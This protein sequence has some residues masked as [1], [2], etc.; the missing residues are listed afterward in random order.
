MMKLRKK[1]VVYYGIIIILIIYIAFIDS[2][3]YFQRYRT[4]LKLE[5]VK[6]DLEA[7]IKENRRLQEENEKLEQ[8]RN[9]WEKKA[10]ELGMQKNGDEVFIFKEKK[11]IK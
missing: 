3:S 4:Q 1:D 9:I 7:I 10:R 5:A 6:T 2:A 11:E 8:D